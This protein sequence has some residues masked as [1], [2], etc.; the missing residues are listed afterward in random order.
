MLKDIEIDVKEAKHLSAMDKNGASDPYCRLSSNFNKQNFKTPCIPKTLEPVWKN[1]KYKFLSPPKEG[2]I[3]IQL[4]D[5]DRFSRD[6]FL[7][8]VVLDI[9]SFPLNKQVDEWYQLL[10]E[11]AKPTV[12]KKDGKKGIVRLIITVSGTEKAKASSEKKEVKETLEDNYEVGDELGRGGFSVPC[13][14]LTCF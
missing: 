1:A 11:P 3:T 9:S 8:R 4:F 12:A 14:P 2:K 10:D 7:G 13:A 6:D 5:R